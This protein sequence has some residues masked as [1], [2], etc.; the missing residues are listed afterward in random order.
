MI[1]DEAT[2]VS[3]QT[4][5]TVPELAAS[6]AASRAA[7]VTCPESHTEAE[8]EGACLRVPMFQAREEK[9]QWNGAANLAVQPDT[10]GS[11]ARQARGQAGQEKILLAHPAGG[12]RKR[13]GVSVLGCAHTHKHN[14]VGVGRVPQR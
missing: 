1:F 7:V 11:A 14:G 6:R 12:E 9:W 3:A 5:R 4:V 10:G 8:R 13:G 2:T